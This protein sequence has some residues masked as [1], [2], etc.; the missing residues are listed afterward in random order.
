[1]LGLTL[2]L[3]FEVIL[4]YGT[5]SFLFLISVVMGL[6]TGVPELEPGFSPSF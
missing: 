2:A 3:I 6:F 5:L 4:A 1:M